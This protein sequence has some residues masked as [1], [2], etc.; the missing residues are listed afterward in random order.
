LAHLAQA[1]AAGVLGAT[2]LGLLYIA[3]SRGPAIVVAP[4][5]A[6][7]AVLPV[8]AGAVA[9][10]NLGFIAVLGIVLAL[11]GAVAAAWEPGTGPPGK[12][13]HLVAGA[14][15][16]LAAAVAIG[17]LLILFDHAAVTSPTWAATGV[18]AG[19][20]GGALA[21]LMIKPVRHQILRPRPARMLAVMIVIGVLNAVGDLAFAFASAHGQLAVVAVLA[22]LYPVVTV[23]LAAVLLRERVR[24]TQAIGAAVALC[25]VVLLGAA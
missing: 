16:A 12:R 2:E 11:T 18:Q 4:V 20:L 14:L 25:G 8:I 19:G 17:V 1:L 6:A 7:G 15:P 9:G 3:I 5:A 21:L 10:N 23:L 13:R 24:P 22:S